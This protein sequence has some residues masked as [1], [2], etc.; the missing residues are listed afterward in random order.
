MTTPT[1]LEVDDPTPDNRMEQI[2][3]QID[4]H[5][6]LVYDGDLS[7]EC[8]EIIIRHIRFRQR[9]HNQGFDNLVSL[10]EMHRDDAKQ[11]KLLGREEADPGGDTDDNTRAAPA[12]PHVE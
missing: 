12:E 3:Q 8:Y 1:R 5:F 11:I 7:T 4:K 10:I 6:G 9:C 2:C